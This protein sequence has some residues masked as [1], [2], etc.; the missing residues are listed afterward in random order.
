MIEHLFVKQMHS[1]TNQLEQGSS[2]EAEDILVAVLTLVI[3]GRIPGPSPTGCKKF[4]DFYEG[5][6]SNKLIGIDQTHTCDTNNELV[7]VV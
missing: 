5:P 7:R 6:H 3:E 1:L 4:K 2:H